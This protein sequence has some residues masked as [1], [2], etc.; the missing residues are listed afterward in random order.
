MSK[1]DELPRFVPPAPTHEYTPAP[2]EPIPENDNQNRRLRRT[3]AKFEVPVGVTTFPL[4]NNN[5]KFILCNFTHLEHRPMSRFPGFR[6]LGAFSNI[7]Q[8]K[9]HQRLHY[10]TP[11]CSMF[12]LAAHELSA[13]CS[14]TEKQ[15]DPEFINQHVE[16][17]VK[18]Y[19]DSIEKINEDFEE[20][21]Q[22]SATGKVG[23]STFAKT[24]KTKKS[25]KQKF[26]TQKY[27]QTVENMPKTNVLSASACV[28]KQSFAVIITIKDTRPHALTGECEKEPL[29]AVLDVFATEEN[30][31]VYAKYT[32]SRHY[33]KCSIDVV[34][35][36]EWC[37]P[38]HIDIDK[39]KEVYAQEKLNHIMQGRKDQIETTK[40]FEEWCSANNVEP[41]YVDVDET[42][43]QE[44]IADQI[45]KREQIINIT[46]LP[47]QPE[48]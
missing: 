36:Y 40:K 15:N 4:V 47:E 24:T 22:K 43:P 11:E 16:T 6:I 14:C 32:A 29:L 8:L 1:V 13:I 39:I 21:V 27:K 20:N 48:I 2:I 38:E 33:G 34:D 18:L 5:H 41:Q 26:V 19:E 28:A 37:F 25:E 3:K 31:Q 23:K 45:S 44:S 10:P 30:A 46:E 42:Q 9:S 12:A 17:I 7:E 35:M